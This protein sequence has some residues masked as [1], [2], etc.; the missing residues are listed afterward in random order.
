[1]KSVTL[2]KTKPDG[3]PSAQPLFSLTWIKPVLACTGRSHHRQTADLP[4][5]VRA[6]CGRCFSKL[7]HYQNRTQLDAAS[8]C[9]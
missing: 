1:M 5:P 6:S 7:R 4:L 9:F 2:A 3:A 8:L